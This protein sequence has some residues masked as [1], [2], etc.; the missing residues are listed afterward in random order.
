MSIFPEGLATVLHSNET[1][2]IGNFSDVR[3][4]RRGAPPSGRDPFHD[5][6][7]SFFVFSIADRDV[8]SASCA[9]RYRNRSSNSPG[10][11]LLRQPPFLSVDLATLLLAIRFLSEKNLFELI[12]S[13]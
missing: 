6:V 1:L 5:F 9:S 4:E 10:R 3:L 12:F 11:R 13:F 8:G 2:A 7:G